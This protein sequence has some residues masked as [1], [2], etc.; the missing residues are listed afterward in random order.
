[1]EPRQVGGVEIPWATQAGATYKAAM[2]PRQ[3]G[4]VEGSQILGSLSCGNF[5]VRERGG[6]AG[7]RVAAI[8][9]SRYGR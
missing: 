7:L 9:E 5:G 2:E 4:G 8:Y 6:T 3:V 1:M